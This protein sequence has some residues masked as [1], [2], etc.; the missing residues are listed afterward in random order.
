M[1]PKIN[2]EL[3]NRRHSGGS[4]SSGFSSGDSDDEN[5]AYANDLTS[6]FF[7]LNATKQNRQHR[8]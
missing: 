8:Y 1:K 5:N 6:E 3:L 7:K 4:G 2:I